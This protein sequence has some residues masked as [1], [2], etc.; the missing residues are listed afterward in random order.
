MLFITFASVQDPLGPAHLGSGRFASV[1]DPLASV[2]DSFS[3]SP[4]LF[5]WCIPTMHRFMFVP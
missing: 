4:A 3:F 5:A 2:Q 1:Q